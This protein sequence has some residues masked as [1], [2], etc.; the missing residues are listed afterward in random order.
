MIKHTK[1]RSFKFINILVPEK[2]LRH[3]SDLLKLKLILRSHMCTSIYILEINY[4]S[5]FLRQ[6][7]S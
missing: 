5:K 2:Y 7:K 1:H 3:V 6:P 4:E